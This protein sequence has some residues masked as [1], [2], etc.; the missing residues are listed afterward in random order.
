MDKGQVDTKKSGFSHF[1]GIDCTLFVPLTSTEA[2]C[3]A[4]SITILSNISMDVPKRHDLTMF[5]V[6]VGSPG[7]RLAQAIPISRL[8]TGSF[9]SGSIMYPPF[10]VLKVHVS[11]HEKGVQQ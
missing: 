10:P 1:P 5:E 2:R 4:L 6:H 9:Y 7:K 11:T 8:P 3:V